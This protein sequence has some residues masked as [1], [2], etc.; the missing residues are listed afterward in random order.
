MVNEQ[1]SASPKEQYYSSLESSFS[2]TQ[3]GPHSS[4][5]KCGQIR[6]ILPFLSGRWIAFVH[7]YKGE[8]LGNWVSLFKID[9]L[10]TVPGLLFQRATWI[11]FFFSQKLYV[12][13][14]DKNCLWLGAMCL[15]RGLTVNQLWRW[16]LRSWVELLL[17]T[18]NTLAESVAGGRRW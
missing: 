6:T 7:T 12:G 14:E 9:F 15:S 5:E 11:Y 1:S 3:K 10:Y 8:M 16:S 17:Q 2:L 4:E 18:A 13:G